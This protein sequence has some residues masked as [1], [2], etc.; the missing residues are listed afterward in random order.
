MTPWSMPW[1][2]SWPPGPPDQIAALPREVSLNPLA[3]RRKARLDSPLGSRHSWRMLTRRDT[4]CLL[5][6]GTALPFLPTPGEAESVVNW[7][8]LMRAQLARFPGCEGK[9][10]LLHF[11]FTAEPGNFHMECAICLDRRAGHRRRVIEAKGP[12]AEGCFEAL[13]ANTA[14]DFDLSWTGPVV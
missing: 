13:M 12:T 10:T 11:Q 7:E 6:A 1:S 2:V 14:R 4:T 3:K 5:L 8:G 9:L